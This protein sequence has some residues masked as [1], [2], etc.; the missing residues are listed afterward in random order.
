MQ[1]SKKRKI[2]ICGNKGKLETLSIL[3]VV[4]KIDKKGKTYNVKVWCKVCAEHK[5]SLNVQLRG[6]AK[7]C[8]LVFIDGTNSVT[9]NQVS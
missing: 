8:T 9:Q 2:K 7:T 1:K 5:S 6:S 3:L 4:K